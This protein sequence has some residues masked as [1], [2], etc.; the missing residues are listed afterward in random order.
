MAAA[1]AAT[2]TAAEDMLLPSPVASNQ[3]AKDMLGVASEAWGT[4][5]KLLA[6]LVHSLGSHSQDFVSSAVLRHFLGPYGHHCLNTVGHAFSMAPDASKVVRMGRFN[7]YVTWCMRYLGEV[8]AASFLW[9]QMV[10]RSP[11]S[12][13]RWLAELPVDF[14]Y[15]VHL[16]TTRLVKCWDVAR[17]AYAAYADAS[18]PEGAP[19]A[20]SVV[21][22]KNAGGHGQQGMTVHGLFLRSGSLRL[23]TG[24]G[25]LVGRDASSSPFATSG[26][27]GRLPDASESSIQ[28][29]QQNQRHHAVGDELWYSPEH[30]DDDDG[31]NAWPRRVV[32]TNYRL[33]KGSTGYEYDILLDSLELKAGAG[34]LRPERQAS[35]NYND[36]HLKAMAGAAQSALALFRNLVVFMCRAQAVLRDRPRTSSISQKGGAAEAPKDLSGFVPAKELLSDTRGGEASS[37]LSQIQFILERAGA[38]DAGTLLASHGPADHEWTMQTMALLHQVVEVVEVEGGIAPPGGGARIRGLIP[39]A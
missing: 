31:F 11:G 5:L 24:S 22:K 7:S 28:Q 23:P 20:G 38:M 27:R 36:E 30:V 9:C 34:E 17:G 33:S 16:A 13:E 35:Q 29:Q 14:H 3:E 2:A 19:S 26:A 15:A 12:A 25:G 21:D 1:A 4:V 32:V 6:V 8:E 18:A 10:S 37:V 39:A